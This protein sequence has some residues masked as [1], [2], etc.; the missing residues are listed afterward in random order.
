MAPKKSSST[1]RFSRREVLRLLGAGFAGTVLPGAGAAAPSPDARRV[2]VIVVGAGMSGLAAA[3]TLRRQGKKVVVLEA[4]DRVGGRVKAGKLAGHTIDLG[5]MWVGPTQ[6]RLLALLREYR[7]ATMPQYLKGKGIVDIAG[8]R[9]TP[10]GEGFGFDS[11]GR[12]SSIVLW[13]CWTI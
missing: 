8:K 6:T 12:P 13:R 1:S 5:G 10:E 11:G 2:D 9:T 7:I 4:R 3:R